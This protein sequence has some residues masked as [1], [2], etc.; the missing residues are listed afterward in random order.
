MVV[1]IYI[2]RTDP[3][4]GIGEGAEI[5][6]TAQKCASFAMNGRITMVLYFLFQGM[7][8]DFSVFPS[9]V[10]ELPDKRL[11]VCA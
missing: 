9:L 11:H 1:R 10:K 7:H 8:S 6:Q 3:V 2:Y 4:I 5:V